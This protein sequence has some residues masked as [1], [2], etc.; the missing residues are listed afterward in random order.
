MSVTVMAAPGNFPFP[1]TVAPIEIDPV[2]LLL[3][4][5]KATT[6]G[7]NGPRSKGKKA[8][9]KAADGPSHT[10]RPPP[11]NQDRL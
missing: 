8:K 1:P 10:P 9:R 3:P 7:G 11:L 5:L 4:S 2:L 6:K